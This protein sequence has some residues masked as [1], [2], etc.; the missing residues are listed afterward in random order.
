MEEENYENKEFKKYLKSCSKE[1]IEFMVKYGEKDIPVVNFEGM[2]F[3]CEQFIKNEGRDL[4]LEILE[5]LYVTFAPFITIRYEKNGKV[6][7]DWNNNKGILVGIRLWDAIQDKMFNKYDWK[8]W[9]VEKKNKKNN[10]GNERMMKQ[11]FEPVNKRIALL[12]EKGFDRS[13]YY[14][15]NKICEL[16]NIIS[17]L[18]GK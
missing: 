16:I 10:W 8:E 1:Q 2:K 4:P 11:Y 18:G 13:Q 5:D 7:H 15:M 17:K 14:N 12:T 9:D 6:H 3:V